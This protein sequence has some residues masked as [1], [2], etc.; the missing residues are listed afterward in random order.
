MKKLL[1]LIWAIC[2]LYIM[3]QNKWVSAPYKY[4]MGQVKSATYL[5]RVDS[6]TGIIFPIYGSGNM[7]FRTKG[8]DR[9]VFD[10]VGNFVLGTN[11][12]NSKFYLGGS[13]AILPRQV[14]TSFSIPAGYAIMYS[15][16]IAEINIS[17]PASSGLPGR[18][19]YFKRI[20]VGNVILN[21]TTVGDSIDGK[22]ADTLLHK[23]DA[24]TI[25]AH[26][27]QWRILTK[28]IQ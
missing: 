19:Y 17:L 27:G 28:Y 8:F 9:A 7:I 15:G 12:G 5:S 10:S 22:K 23:N 1:S 14:D 24:I 25:Q 2:P 4:E 26:A 11:V 6:T 21:A 3:A 16:N 18:I 20:G 13:L